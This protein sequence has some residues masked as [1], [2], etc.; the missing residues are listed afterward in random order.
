MAKVNFRDC[1]WIRIEADGKVKILRQDLY[2]YLKENLHLKI[3]GNGNMYLYDSGCYR[4]ISN[5]E[6][7]A[8]I[9][10]YLPVQFRNNKDWEAVWREFTTDFPDIKEEDFNCDEKHIV[11]KNGVLD[12]SQKETNTLE[13]HSPKYLYTRKIPCNYTPGL[14]LDDAPV[15]KTYLDTLC[16]DDEQAKIFLLEFI[17]AI[18]SNVKGWRFKKLLLLVGE[19]NTGKTQLRE[20]VV[21]LLGK[22]NCISMD[23]AKLNERFASA[24]LWRKRLA[25]SGDMGFV[26]IDEVN[27]LKNLTGGDNLFAEFKGKD[28]FSFVYDGL[29]WFNTNKLPYFRGDRGKHVYERFMIVRCPNIIPKEKRDPQLLDKLLNEKEAIVSVAIEYLKQAIE[30]GYQFT[31]SEFMTCERDDYEIENNSLLCFVSECCQI[32]NGYTRRSEFNKIYV[33]WCRINAVQPE[34]SREIGNLL[35][36]TYQLEASKRNGLYVYPL[37]IKDEELEELE[38]V[39]RQTGQNYRFSRSAKY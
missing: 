15:F 17:G 30:R 32:G 11:F 33:Q 8:L 12:I 25:G 3:S 23:M 13:N 29:L 34:R 5:N 14:T 2:T 1:P 19:G 37:A 21:N 10:E 24:L 9:K 18:I 35:W 22:C 20:F 4:L 27:T 6:L 36:K 7:K 39:L 31:E 38:E 26:T 28:G 16:G